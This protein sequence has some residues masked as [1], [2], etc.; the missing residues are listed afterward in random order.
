MRQE[1]QSCQNKMAKWQYIFDSLG[2]SN[3]ATAPQGQA[4]SELMQISPTGAEGSNIMPR[5]AARPEQ[6]EVRRR[7]RQ[8]SSPPDG[9]AQTIRDV[10]PHAG[11]TAGEAMAFGLE[12]VCQRLHASPARQASHGNPGLTQTALPGI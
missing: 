6:A 4:T 8:G 11:S 12:I 5:Q 2:G 9:V 10:T 7:P 3:A 1:L